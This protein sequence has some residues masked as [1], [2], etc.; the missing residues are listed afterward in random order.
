MRFEGNWRWD[1]Q[2]STFA[3]HK[4]VFSVDKKQRGNRKCGLIRMEGQAG[5]ST[6]Y[7]VLLM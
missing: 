3:V 2:S 7:V 4:L 6:V 1:E 5:F